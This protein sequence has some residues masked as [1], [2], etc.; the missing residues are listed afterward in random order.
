MQAHRNDLLLAGGCFSVAF[1]LFQVSAIWWPS[2]VVAY[3]GGP[4]RL[5]AESPGIY[6]AV[7]I[8]VGLMVAVCGLYAWSGANMVRRLPLLR[9]VVTATTVVYLLRGMQVVSDVILINRYPEQPLGRFL[10]YSSIA[11]AVG[12]VHLFGTVRLFRSTRVTAGFQPA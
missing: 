2:K 4:V 12:L 5:Q 10:V 9:T 3:F 8:L 1:A 6:A 11:L 7:C